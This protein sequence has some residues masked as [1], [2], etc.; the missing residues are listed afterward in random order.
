MMNH[1]LDGGAI[2]AYWQTFKLVKEVVESDAPFLLAGG[3]QCPPLS[4]PI[5]FLRCNVVM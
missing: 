3:V 4:A 2:D 5:F 1:R